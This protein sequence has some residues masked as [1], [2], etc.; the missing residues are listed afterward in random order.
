MTKIVSSEQIFKNAFATVSKK[1][2][3][4]KPGERVQV[5]LVVEKP[6]AVCVTLVD[7]KAR[8]MLFVEQFR[9]GAA[10]HHIGKSPY[11]L[12]PV[13]GH[14]DPGENPEDAAYREVDEETGG[15]KIKNLRS[16][17]EGFTT[18]GIANEMHY[19]YMAE[20]DSTEVDTDKTYGIEGESIKLRIFTIEEAFAKLQS[21]E[22]RSSAAL[23]SVLLAITL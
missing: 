12:E 13:A 3:D 11:L 10:C 21:G 6:D 9:S 5:H 2:L 17:C 18:P 22:I 16:V 23:I 14:I 20:F 7:L 4:S 1:T 15:L 19:H 8:K